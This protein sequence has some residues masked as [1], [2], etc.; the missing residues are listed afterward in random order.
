MYDPTVFENLK[1]AFENKIYDLDTIDR[2]VT[3]RNRS[4]LMDF[5]TLTRK[6]S[7]QF[8]LLHQKDVSAEVV[9]QTSLQD[10]ADE[11]LETPDKDPGCSLTLHFT[12]SVQQVD[13]QCRQ[14]EEALNVIWE[15]DI[16]V[17]QT[18]SFEY[19]DESPGYLNLIEVKFNTKINEEHMQEIPDFLHSVL[20]TLGVLNSI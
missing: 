18:L 10:L 5:A 4:D 2:E 13:E 15:N 7:I 17:T 8:T 3:I 6:L 1:V 14:I 16:K 20:L 19:G 9:L 12:K 11:I